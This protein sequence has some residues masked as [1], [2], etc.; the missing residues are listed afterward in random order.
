VGHLA[1]RL[2]SKSAEGF[3]DQLMMWR[4]REMLRRRE[5]LIEVMRMPLGL[6]FLAGV[7]AL[8][9]CGPSAAPI[10]YNAT[11]TRD[12]P[13]TQRNRELPLGLEVKESKT[14]KKK[15]R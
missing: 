3:T 5:V 12:D 1:T 11:S 7:G 15:K 8:T 9:G 4:R 2:G 6:G 10:D 14:K 13:T